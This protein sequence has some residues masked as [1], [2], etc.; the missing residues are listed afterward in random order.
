MPVSPAGYLYQSSTMRNQWSTNQLLSELNLTR[1]SWNRRRNFV[2]SLS[3]VSKWKYWK[4]CGSISRYLHSLWIQMNRTAAKGPNWTWGLPCAQGKSSC[5]NQSVYHL[6][7]SVHERI[8]FPWQLKL[9]M[10][11]CYIDTYI[12]LAYQSHFPQRCYSRP[13][14]SPSFLWWR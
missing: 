13:L 10:D 1:F 6:S 14:F 11:D 3:P 9:H 7:T 2:L 5:A 8:F 4:A 12:S